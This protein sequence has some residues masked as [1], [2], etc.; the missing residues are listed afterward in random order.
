MSFKSLTVF[1]YAKEDQQKLM[2][3]NSFDG[4]KR[5]LDTAEHSTLF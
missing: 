5:I 3:S 1:N 4:E 2:S